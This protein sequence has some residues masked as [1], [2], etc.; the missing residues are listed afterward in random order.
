M[1][2]L[3]LLGTLFALL[4]TGVGAVAQDNSAAIKELTPTGKL[5][6]AI[7]YGPTP[8]A[9]YALKDAASG[10]Y[11]G[12]T[13]DLSNA[14]AK[15]IGAPLEFVPYLA[16]GEIQASAATGVWD[17]SFMP[18]DEER[19]KFVD[20]GNAYHL[21][22]STYLVTA[23]SNIHSVKDANKPGVRICGVKGTATFRAN[24]A[25]SPSATQLELSGPDEQLA[26]MLAG[27]CDA[28]ALSRESLTGIAPKIPGSRILDDAFLS[29]STAVAVPKNKP[30]ALA[31]VGAFIEEAK[32]SGLVRKSFDAVGMTTSQLA[33]AGMKP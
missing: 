17:V 13:I 6:A 30:A 2:H 26:A 31:Y 20:F 5:R 29:S 15:K 4:A 10:R 3:G 18:V 9:L 19:K 27:K 16:S 28:M 24:A 8:S 14:L 33:P 7:A 22:Q 25:A 21:L 23:T 32:A 12:V 1:R 11:R